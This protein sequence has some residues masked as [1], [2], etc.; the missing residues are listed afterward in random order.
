VSSARRLLRGD[1]GGVQRR[2]WR[3]PRVLCYH[4][5]D[6]EA[7]CERFGFGTFI[8]SNSVWCCSG[9]TASGPR[10]AVVFSVQCGL[11]LLSP[12]R[13]GALF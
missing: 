3:G 4:G 5:G 2:V 1:E 13:H 7:A 6:C 12:F 11:F 10:M 8:L 9:T